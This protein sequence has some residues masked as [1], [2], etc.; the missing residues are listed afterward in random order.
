MAVNKMCNNTL[1]GRETG[2]DC[3][4]GSGNGSGGVGGRL[5]CSCGCTRLHF[6]RAKNKNLFPPSTFY[7]T[8]EQKERPYKLHDLYRE[9][10]D[11]RRGGGAC[12]ENQF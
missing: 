10:K 11:L 6:F 9:V 7:D 3:S 8:T 1:K 4:T 5:T 2:S 12:Q